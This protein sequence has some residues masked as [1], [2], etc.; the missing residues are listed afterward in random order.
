[1]KRLIT[2]AVMAVIVAV[3]PLTAVS[4]SDHHR[5]VYLSLGDSVAAGTQDP[6]PFTDDGYTDVLF[7][8]ARGT[9]GLTEHVNLAC[10]GDDTNEF[11]NGDDG[12]NGGSL[13]YGAGA[14]F[15]FGA[16]S[17]LDA[18]LAYLEANQGDVALIT[19]TIG[20]NDLM[21]CNPASPECVQG[22][23][24]NA[25]A[26]LGATILPKLR[27]AA[28]DTP[29]LGMNYY[30]PN[31][32]YWLTPGGA[33]IAEQSNKLVAVSNEVLAASYRAH[34]I[35]V[36]DVAEAFHIYDTGS[37]KVPKNVRDT[38]RFT[39]MCESIDGEWQL[40]P[41]PDIHP[42]DLGYKRIAWAFKKAVI[43]S[44]IAG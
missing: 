8:R 36:V 24:N 26:N 38:C 19:I 1:M 11:I 3:L 2:P 29:I 32:A 35:P 21:S 9:M 16:A 28:A 41:T 27:A 6:D 20:A 43:Q 42:T 22:V 40:S 34:D 7:R 31:L 39:G 30:N 23:L 18:A 15:A 25:A 13:C 5:A 4:A 37:S 14:P 10:P 12:P 33:A 17:Q 44:G